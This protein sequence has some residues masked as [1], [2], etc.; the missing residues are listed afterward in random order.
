MYETPMLIRLAIPSQQKPYQPFS[1]HLY[2]QAKQ[3]KF[4]LYGYG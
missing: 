1:R 3:C 4:I 2:T